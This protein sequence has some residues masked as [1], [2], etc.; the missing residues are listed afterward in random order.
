M[1]F[2]KPYYPYASHLAG[3][4][5]DQRVAQAALYAKVRQAIRGDV[6]VRVERVIT[7]AERQAAWEKFVVGGGK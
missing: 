4:G 6:E 1:R 7:Q 2:F 5:K 3:V